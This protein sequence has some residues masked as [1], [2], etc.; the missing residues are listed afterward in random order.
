MNRRIA[1][2]AKG[3]G[4]LYRETRH[5]ETAWHLDYTA[6]DGKRRRQKLASDRKVAEQMRIQ[7]IARR[8]REVS[9]LGII[10]GQDRLLAELCDLYLQDLRLRA[11]AGHLT[12][13]SARLDKALASLRAQRVRDLAPA[14]VLALQGALGSMLAWAVKM[15]LIEENP[16]KHLRPLPI[17]EKTLRRRPRALSEDEIGRLMAVAEAEDRHCCADGPRQIP[18]APFLRVALESGCRYGEL[19]QL[20]WGA[21]DFEGATLLV[22][23]EHAKSAKSRSIP[24]RAELLNALA[25]LQRHHARHLGRA[26]QA[27]DH[28]FLAPRG[29]VWLN[30]SN[31]ANRM[32]YRMLEAAGIPR[33]DDVGRQVSMHGLR[34]SFCTRVIANGGSLEQARL[35][36][37]HADVRLTSRVYAH[38][39]TSQTRSAIDKLPP[40]GSPRPEQPVAAKLRLA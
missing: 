1:S 12:N 33:I 26:V 24:I 28:V 15:R 39:D 38:L 17:N 4:R 21:I 8:D 13:K 9:G 22:R 27:H 7:L 18:Q 25:E 32:L 6:S 37:G 30:C 10:G 2:R 14:D 23:G 11:G 34:H 5:G 16:I 40:T 31:N 19:R 20:R 35:L 29:E 36:M 3:P